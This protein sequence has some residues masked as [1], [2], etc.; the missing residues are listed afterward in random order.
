MAGPKVQHKQKEAVNPVQKIQPCGDD[1]KESLE[2]N[3][4]K[5]DQIQESDD[6]MI[7]TYVHKMF[8][9]KDRKLMG[10]INT[11]DAAGTEAYPLKE[12]SKEDCPLNRSVV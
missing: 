1:N 10:S 11:A 7:F 5:K 6:E 2:L 4:I 12:A 9:T 3:K 8:R